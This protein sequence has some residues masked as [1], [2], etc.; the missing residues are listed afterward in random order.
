MKK[1][2]ICV[3][4]LCFS[5]GAYAQKA[6]WQNLDLKTDSVF[7]ISTEKAYQQLLEHKK[8]TT[9]LV[10]VV[11]GG[12]DTSHEDLKA[13]IWNNPGEV[14]GNGKDDDH[15]GYVDDIHG[16]DFIGGPTGDVNYDNLEL[17]RVLRRDKSKYE[18]L[19]SSTVS[20]QDKPGW[21]KYQKMRKEYDQ[22]W[23]NSQRTLEGIRGFQDV[24]LGVVKAI[25]KDTPTIADFQQYQPKDAGEQQV[26]KV[27]IG[28]MQSGESFTQ[29]K[30]DDL[31]GALKHFQEK[32]D[33]QLN[34]SYD[35]RS[36][37]GDDYSNSQQRNYGNTDVTG[38]DAD[39]GTHVSG[40]IGAVRDN[41]IGIKGV[42][43]DVRI[44]AVRVVPNGDERDKDVANGIRYAVD[45]GARVINMSFGKGYSWDKK[46]VD[47]AVK[48]AMSKDVLLVH[49]AGNDG[50]DLGTVTNFP[51][52]IYADSSGQAAAWIEVGASGF[53]DDTTLAASFSN[54]GKTQVDVFAPGV[55]IYST[56]PGSHYANHDGTSMAAPVV[57]GLAALIREYYPKLSAVQV[58]DIIMKSVVKPTHPVVIAVDGVSKTVQLSDICVSGG[59]VNAY[60]AL[61]LAAKYKK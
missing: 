20:P 17:V 14:P 39:H 59:V 60:Q 33:F 61:E 15:N 48:Y 2:R 23:E 21:E 28:Q 38:P 42:A 52:R 36:I 37:V 57:T 22:E 19:T 11:D 29:F 50:Q 46:A 27:A 51:T 54:Y 56:T 47:D 31:G 30:D 44:I 49:A 8:P 4:F 34:L 41:N 18:S 53:N 16:W 43:N 1:N 10:A 55:S 3:I 45:N 58:K 6:N 32:V 12:V 5:V 24:F 35:P 9:V 25:G 40:I 7:G 26:T 13:I